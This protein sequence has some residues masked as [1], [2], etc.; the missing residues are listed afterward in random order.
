MKVPSSELE[1]LYR[2]LVSTEFN[3]MLRG[4][5]SLRDVYRTVKIRFRDLCDD[6][7][8]C[9][10]ICSSGGNS[11]EW[12]HRVRAALQALKSPSGPVSKSGKHG[13]WIFK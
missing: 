7:L 11:P 10:E 1:E 6:N 8:L 2:Q 12:Q 3:F 4:S 9:S 13:Y 5:H